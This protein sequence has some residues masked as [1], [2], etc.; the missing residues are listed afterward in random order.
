MRAEHGTWRGP[1]RSPA[2]ALVVDIRNLALRAAFG[3]LRR[4]GDM[5]E[6]RCHV[7]SAI[8]LGA[9]AC[10]RLC[11]VIVARDR[12]TWRRRLFPA[13]K[14]DD[15]GADRD[16]RVVEAAMV[17]EEDV[18]ALLADCGAAVLAV[19]GA[20]ADDIAA[21]LQRALAAPVV[22]VSGDSDWVQVL[23]VPQSAL[24]Q[25]HVPWILRR[26]G[27][28]RPTG[29][30]MPLQVTTR[31]TVAEGEGAC[32]PEWWEFLVFLRCVRGRPEYGMPPAIPRLRLTR[33]TSLWENRHDA[34][35]HGV[36][37]GGEDP[38]GEDVLHALARNREVFDWRYVPNDV[39]MAVIDAL[40][41]ALDAQP[42]VEAL[43]AIHDFVGGRWRDPSPFAARAARIARFTAV[44][45]R[46]AVEAASG[47][48]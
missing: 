9:R 33:A 3:L 46:R 43:S 47:P 7:L 1:P 15:R 18:C 42:R 32:P 11:P 26:D 23:R 34:W 38:F 12:G 14:R 35:S 25:A 8:E 20:E 10:E 22:A 37:L 27:A 29:G 16:R 24:V 36:A 17:L 31:A 39:A 21:T 41:E 13:W 4:G 48:A 30:K 44:P 28:W 5:I 19:D 45:V 6:A 40:G 2:T